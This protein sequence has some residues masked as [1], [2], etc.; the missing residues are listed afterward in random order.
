MKSRLSSSRLLWPTPRRIKGIS[1]KR[2]RDDVQHHG[3]RGPLCLM[4]VVRPKV[5]FVHLDGQPLPFGGRHHLIAARHGSVLLLGSLCLNP[6]LA[7]DW[8]SVFPFGLVHISR[9]VG[10]QRR[11]FAERVLHLSKLG[12]F[13]ERCCRCIRFFPVLSRTNLDICFLSW[14][15]VWIRFA[16]LAAQFDVAKNARSS[17]CSCAWGRWVI[18]QC[19]GGTQ[20]SG[21]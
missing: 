18:I 10:P 2:H 7:Q 1:G 13:I 20:A 17:K 12:V 3:A 14:F 6:L 16:T 5:R 15:L 9:H 19:C 8:T 21:R 11:D 4:A